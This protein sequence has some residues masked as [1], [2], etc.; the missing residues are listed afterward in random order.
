MEALLYFDIFSH[1]LTAEEAFLFSRHPGLQMEAV[2]EKLEQLR[3]DKV[4]FYFNGFFQLG[5]DPSK[6]QRR[7]EYNRRADQF[8]PV[9]A[10][11]AR[12]IGHFPYI[13]GV[14]VSGSLSK[15]CMRPD[16]DIDFF[17]V[18]EPGRLWLARTLLAVFKKL[19][20]FNSHKYFCINY[21]VDTGHLAI[22]DR[23]LFAAAE[24]V[25][26]LPMYGSDW[27]TAF[28]SA[29]AWAYSHFP[30]FPLRPHA[31]VPPHRCGP[32]KKM[33]ERM[34]NNR[35]G[36]WLDVMTMRITTGF[37]KRKFRHLDARLY[38]HAFRSGRHVS[39]H[40]PL[41]FQHRVMRE[42]DLRL[43]ALEGK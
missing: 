12:L 36:D 22:E 38:D 17:L 30:H 26:L 35:L 5:D 13:R 34:F 11:M 16:S 28:C 3:Q 10:R 4:I 33:L 31:E 6:T 43:R 39:K 2:A 19:F 7:V 42:F 27:Y 24:T 32:V 18:T 9:A 37:W 40:H 23:N 8:L 14:F 1:P 25:T 21:F 41:G 20:L 29:N 15:H